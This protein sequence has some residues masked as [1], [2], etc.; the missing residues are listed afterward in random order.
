MNGAPAI[1]V[2][3]PVRDGERYIGEALDSI[4]AQTLPPAEVI[5]V[6]DGSEDRTASVVDR[7]GPPVRYAAQEPRGVSAAVNRGLDLA[8][9]E[10]IAFL[11]ADDLWEPE[12]LELQSAVLAH[13]PGLDLVFCLVEQFISPELS[14]E[15]QAKIRRPTG[16][17]P[18]PLKAALLAR[19]AAIDRVGRFD[20]RWQITDFIDWFARAKEAGLRTEVLPRVLLRRRLHARNSTRRYGHDE[21]ARVLAETV[22]RRK[23]AAGA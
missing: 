3:V 19:R 23:R 1:S 12:K 16:Q 13:D 10:L 2:I 21:Y 9:G 11:D 22:R 17:V 15:E 8:A 4:L 20:E 14:D 7:Y 18:A 6:D 5:V